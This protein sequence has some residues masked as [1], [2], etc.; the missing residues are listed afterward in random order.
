MSGRGAGK[1]VRVPRLPVVAVIGVLLIA[2]GLAD[3]AGSGHAAP[4]PPLIQPMPVAAPASSLSSA[5]F[6]A[7][8]TGHPGQ[9]ADGE[10]VVANASGRALSGTALL[11]PSQGRSVSVPFR[12]EA[13]NRTTLSE[14][15]AG[16]APF[17]AALVEL[18]GGEAAV[19]Q[20]V[21][22]AQGL[23]TSACAT[24]GSEHWYFADGTTQENSSLLISLFNPYPDDAIVDLSFTTEQGAEA[25][26]DFQAVVVPAKGVVGLD[27]GTHLR[28]RA[29]VA[30]S[31]SVRAGRIVAFKT[32]VVTALPP[33]AAASSTASPTRVPGLSLVLG[34]PS[35]ATEL[36]WP[37]G[38]ATTGQTERYQIYN[39]T[40]APA[41]LSLFVALDE[42]SADPF[43]LR[44]PP[45]GTA[46]IVSN[47]EARVPRGVGHA[48]ELRSTN[49]VGVVAERTVD[50]VSP[51]PQL[52]LADVGGVRLQA[53]RWLLAAG[54]ADSALDESIAVYNPG[55]SAVNLSVSSLDG[56]MDDVGGLAGLALPPGRR[57]VVRLNDHSPTLARALVVEA[58]GNVIV[59]RD[60]SRV[61]GVGIDA[62]IGVPLDAP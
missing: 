29:Q 31:V 32:Q 59:E 17:V 43:T 51:S 45:G 22:G 47:A 1:G 3:R 55:T 18:D 58:S 26:S 34:A 6:C 57:L 48:A 46:A 23:S 25:P 15:P 28:R 5:W 53:R 16:S 44:V 41:D 7:G 40:P 33:A 4:A 35:P 62:T 20:V 12:V 21:T 56:A 24:T 2:G 49:G 60:I 13:D 38:L 39:P 27:L 10:L 8:A 42:G 52:G 30:T 14:A 50:A 54:S 11:I 61:K 37:A 9:Q 36:W 19:E